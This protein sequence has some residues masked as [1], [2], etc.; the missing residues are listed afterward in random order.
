MV[1][2]TV[3]SMLQLV[4]HLYSIK[5]T[6]IENNL[7]KSFIWMYLH[8]FQY[9]CFTEFPPFPGLWLVEQCPHI[10]RQMADSIGYGWMMDGP[11]L[12]R[13]TFLFMLYWIP[14]ISQSLIGWAVSMHLQTNCGLDLWQIWSANSSWASPGLINFWSCSTEFPLF[15]SLWLVE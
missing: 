4:F 13:W 12:V 10:C 6:C 14:T 3:W 1:Q 9:L 15:P 5:P 8:Q 2:V 7:V 11:L